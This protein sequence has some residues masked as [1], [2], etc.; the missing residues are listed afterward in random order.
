MLAKCTE[1]NLQSLTS[2]ESRTVAECLKGFK[3]SSEEELYPTVLVAGYTKH[4]TP[5]SQTDLVPSAA[6]AEALDAKAPWQPR[7]SAHPAQ[8]C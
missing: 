7:P 8:G 6:I 3:V 5:A 4:Q 2:E 1:G